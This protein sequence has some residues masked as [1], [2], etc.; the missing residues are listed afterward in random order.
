MPG[1]NELREELKALKSEK[2]ALDKGWIPMRDKA[3]KVD[4]KIKET[5]TALRIVDLSPRVSDHALFR[6]L[7]R[8]YAVDFDG[9]REEIL[10]EKV[11]AAIKAGASAITVDGYKYIITE[12]CITTILGKDQSILSKRTMRERRD[13]YKNEALL[14]QQ[15]EC[16]P[17]CLTLKET[18]C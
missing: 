1:R 7:Q 6:Y 14:T 5:M 15:E 2:L 9:L 12:G 11:K 4:E 8:K 10:T 18:K 13:D 16:M 3:R 17:I